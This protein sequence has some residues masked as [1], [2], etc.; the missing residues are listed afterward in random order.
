MEEPKPKKASPENTGVGGAGGTRTPAKGDSSAS[1]VPRTT[2][3]AAFI[4]ETP[5]PSPAPGSAAPEETF[6]DASPT[7]VPGRPRLSEV[8]PRKVQFQPGDLLGGRFE[9]LQVLGEGGMGTVYKAVDRE[10]DHVVALKLIRPELAVHPAILARFKQELLTARQVTHRNVIR[11]HDLS[12]VDGVKFITMEFVEGCDL[13]KLL[14]DRGKLPPEEA[15]E[16][17][18]QVCLALDAA[19]SAG[20]IH[21]DLKPQNVMQDKQGRILVMDFGL[22]RSLQSDGMTQTGALLGRVSCNASC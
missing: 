6:V 14:I 3:G 2:D 8:F 10:V 22:A 16:I 7:P 19:H 17:I 11:I 21:R 18:R 15:V 20:V 13:R 1:D 5:A 9:I 4:R 12:E